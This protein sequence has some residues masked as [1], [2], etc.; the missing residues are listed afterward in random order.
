MEYI[1]SSSSTEVNYNHMKHPMLVMESA[2]EYHKLVI[3]LWL[4]NSRNLLGIFW[5]FYSCFTFFTELIL[6]GAPI[7]ITQD[8]NLHMSDEEALESNQPVNYQ[9]HTHPCVAYSQ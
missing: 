6:S 7:L 4:I 5:N 8:F 1:F 9:C 2:K 3:G